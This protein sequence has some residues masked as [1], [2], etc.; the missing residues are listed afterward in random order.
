MSFLTQLVTSMYA[1]VASDTA[2]W[3]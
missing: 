2:H 3:W 1:V